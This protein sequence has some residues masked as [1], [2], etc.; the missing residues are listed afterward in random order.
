MASK[1]RIDMD[2]KQALDQAKKLEDAADSMD[3]LS[4]T[5]FNGTLQNISNCWKGDSATLYLQKG[6]ALQKEMT[7][8]AVELRGIASDIRDTAERIHEAE[9]RNWER[10]RR[11]RH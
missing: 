4:G 10:A 1:F 3:K 7:S 11:R 9:I 2:F 6:M 5:K 8:T